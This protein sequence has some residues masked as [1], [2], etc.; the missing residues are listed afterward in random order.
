MNQ[1]RSSG[2]LPGN[3]TREVSNVAPSA[4]DLGERSAGPDPRREPAAWRRANQLFMAVFEAS[5]LGMSVVGSDGRFVLVNSALSDMLGS[6]ADEL[7][8]VSVSERTHP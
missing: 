6:P 4:A 2:V 8:G 5:P 7:S 3:A 1:S